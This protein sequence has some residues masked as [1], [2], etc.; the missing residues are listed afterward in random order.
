MHFLL[1][2]LIS[3]NTNENDPWPQEEWENILL[4]V[5]KQN[6]LGAFRKRPPQSRGREFVHCWYFTD[7]GGDWGSSDSESEVFVQDLSKMSV[8]PLRQR[9]GSQFWTFCADVF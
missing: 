3:E 6:T 4:R 5:T 7:K 2:L 9:R 1:F 8:C